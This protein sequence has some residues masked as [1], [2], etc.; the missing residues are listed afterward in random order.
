MKFLNL[1]I[2]L[3][4]SFGIYAQKFDWK[5]RIGGTDSDSSVNIQIDKSGFVYTSGI[6]YGEIDLNQDTINKNNFTSKGLSDFYIQKTNPFGEYVWGKQFGSDSIDRITHVKYLDNKLYI[7]GQ[8]SRSIKLDAV[9]LNSNGKL[10]AFL[11]VLDTSGTVIWAKAYGGI[12]NDR[13]TTLSVNQNGIYFS[14]IFTGNILN[15]EA[16]GSV[17]FANLKNDGSEL[18]WSNKIGDLNRVKPNSS[19]IDSKG[20]VIF[21]G[22]FAGEKI[23][24]NP[25]IKDSLLSSEKKP[26]T[27]FYTQDCFILKLDAKG[28]FIY[29]KKIG[30]ST[31]DDIIFDSYLT[32]ERLAITGQISGSVVFGGT[33]NS[34]T[35]ISNGK[36][37]VFV[38]LYNEN[39]ELIWVKNTGGLKTD[40]GKSIYLDSNL[41]VYIT[42]TFFDTDGKGVDFDP[43]TKVFKLNSSTS[44]NA[45]VWKLNS[46]GDYLY[47][48]SFGG[49]GVDYASYICANDEEEIFTTGQFEK[50]ATFYDEKLVSGGKSD[51]YLLKSVSEKENGYVIDYALDGMNPDSLPFRLEVGKKDIGN[52]P[53][54]NKKYILTNTKYTNGDTNTLLIDKIQGPIDST[55]VPLI[56]Y[57]SKACSDYMIGKKDDWYLP[58]KE[59]L[60]LMYKNRKSIGGMKDYP[61]WCS[62]ETDL[63]NANS[64]DFTDGKIKPT[65]NKAERK[66]VRPVRKKMK[67]DGLNTF[68]LI[69][70][71]VLPNPTKGECFINL[72]Q[73][74]VQNGVNIEIVNS[75]GQ[76]IKTE[77]QNINSFQVDLSSLQNGMYFIKLYNES[78]NSITKIIKE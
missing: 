43:S 71:D 78:F 75:A 41:N 23:D 7:A 55:L 39:G 49:S 56:N 69:K 10:D 77:K 22:S 50:E 36:E 20:N 42:G 72:D 38:S 8:F 60:Q 73:K 24:F 70:V 74:Y 44:Q 12:N 18:I 52:L 3:F 1:L 33:K 15:Q 31:D 51:V 59:E 45:F 64:I 54:Y 2:V 35:I 65:S 9:Q 61:Y 34:K 4:F 37:D 46:F 19:S 68:N 66:Y 29:V 11:A 76:L 67:N 40:L 14:G 27:T 17:V 26:N 30:G 62:S 21:V 28:E 48:G 53:W 6:F 5:G 57:A 63:N 32:K 16:N 47:A 25:S 58:S 13:I